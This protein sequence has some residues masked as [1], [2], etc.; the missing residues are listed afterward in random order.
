[1]P[2]PARH[3]PC[4]KTR[5]TNIH[6]LLHTSTAT[7]QLFLGDFPGVVHSKLTAVWIKVLRPSLF[8]NTLR[9]SHQADKAKLAALPDRSSSPVQVLLPNAISMPMPRWLIKR[10]S[11]VIVL[12]SIPSAQVPSRAD[13]FVV[14]RAVAKNDAIPLYHGHIKSSL[15]PSR[16]RSKTG[17]ARVLLLSDGAPQAT[18]HVIMESSMPISSSRLSIASLT[19]WLACGGSQ[20]TL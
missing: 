10:P 15:E 4:R 17:R 5:S 20:H 1:M 2:S 3:L 9:V 16:P 8:P 19:C 7:L 6:N 18:H 14:P 11:R 12:K 13:R